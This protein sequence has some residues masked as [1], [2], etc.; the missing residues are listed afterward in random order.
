[1]EHRRRGRRR[2][3]F[4]FFSGETPTGAGSNGVSS[5]RAMERVRSV[6]APAH[7]ERYFT[8]DFEFRVANA[9]KVPRDVVRV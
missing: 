6:P 1:M 5:E 8:S 9:G 7:G 4:R 2:Q 3:H